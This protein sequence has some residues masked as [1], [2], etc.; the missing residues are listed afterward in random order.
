MEENKEA[1]VQELG[2]LLRK[3]SREDVAG[4]DYDPRNE[5]VYITYGNGYVK[6]VNVACDSCIAIMAD[7]YKALL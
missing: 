6:P 1:F 4:L 7:V 2:E 5:T 3:Y